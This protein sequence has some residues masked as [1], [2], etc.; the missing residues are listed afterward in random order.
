MSSRWSKVALAAIVATFAAVAIVHA[1]SGGAVI[2]ACVSNGDGS[3]RILSDPTGYS[4][5]NQSCLSA[6]QQHELTWNQQ[7][8][9][10]PAGATGATGATGSSGDGGSGRNFI[11]YGDSGARKVSN[12][13]EDFIAAA[14]CPEGHYATGGGYTGY[15][16]GKLVDQDYIL[17][18]GPNFNGHVDGSPTFA[19]GWTVRISQSVVGP[20][21]AGLKVFAIC[22]GDPPP[23]FN[24]SPRRPS[25]SGKVH[26]LTVSPKLKGTRVIRVP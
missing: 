17:Y 23:G 26:K 9:A 20:G 18:D 8:P 24:Q 3:L 5:S 21:T 2:R 12:H 6:N 13:R 14:D 25:I 15:G 11:V 1:Q 7:G 10:G 4:N 22:T 16:T 19:K